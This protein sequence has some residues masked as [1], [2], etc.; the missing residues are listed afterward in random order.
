VSGATKP[1]RRALRTSAV[2]DCSEG[3]RGSARHPLRLGAKAQPKH[4]KPGRTAARDGRSCA[5]RPET[6]RRRRSH[7]TEPRHRR[8]HRGRGGRAAAHPRGSGLGEEVGALPAP[9]LPAQPG[10]RR[11]PPLP[12]RFAGATRHQRAR[13][14]P[15]CPRAPRLAGGGRQR[16][17][18]L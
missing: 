9:R 6:R 1:P 7:A 3:V 5:G 12:P 11:S 17:P 14:P 2:I 13:P 18:G 15:P 8:R 16:R 10:L 4:R